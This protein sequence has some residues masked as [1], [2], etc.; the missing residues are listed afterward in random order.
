MDD[1]F[2]TFMVMSSLRWL[3]SLV[4]KQDIAVN[5]IEIEKQITDFIFKGIGR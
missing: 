5:P 3:F 4:T 2:A 1:K